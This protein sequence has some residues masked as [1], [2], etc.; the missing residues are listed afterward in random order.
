MRFKLFKSLFFIHIVFIGFLSSGVS[1]KECALFLI[2]DLKSAHE[3]ALETVEFPDEAH[4][5]VF[6]RILRIALYEAFEGIDF[7][8]GEPLPYEFMSIDHVL[9]KSLGGPNNVANYVPTTGAVNSKK[10]N[11]FDY[12][13]LED[14][15]MIRD[16]YYQ[17]VMANLRLYGAF[18]N[19]EE[20]LA[21]AIEAS[22]KK[23]S[24]KDYRL[25]KDRDEVLALLNKQATVFRR[26]ISPL[27]S[28][29][30]EILYLFSQELT[31]LS[32]EKFNQ[33]LENRHFQ[34]QVDYKNAPLIQEDEN[35]KGTFI[36]LSHRPRGGK[37]Q[38][39]TFALK[40]R[41]FKITAY[42]YN[43][44]KDKISVSITFH[45]LLALKLLEAP[46]RKGMVLEFIKDLLRPTDITSDEFIEWM[47]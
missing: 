18:E 12:N 38:E 26:K 47:E 1:A 42:Y 13:N 45:P 17:K 23:Y 25:L 27:S 30:L 36:Y 44:R 37:I 43:S 10:G 21:K 29:D 6:E 11:S 14:L 35:Y 41:V 5:Y 32:Q 16:V 34:F 20:D 40:N 22:K 28:Q 33:V 4:F 19:R 24:Y 8:T 46:S 7:Y 3:V 15:K 2:Q 9:P 39:D 31:N